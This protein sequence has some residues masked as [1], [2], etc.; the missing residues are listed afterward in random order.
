MY[1][2]QRKIDPFQTNLEH[3]I[4]FFTSLFENGLGYSSI[5]SARSA[6][7]A[8]GLKFDTILVGQHPLVIRYLKGV[9][10]LR[11]TRP[12]YSCVWDVQIVLN[13]LCKLSPVKLI[14]R[15]ELTLKLTM[16]LALTN[17]T[18]VQSLHLIS[19]NSVI[20]LKSE[21]VF[22]VDG[23]LKQSRPGYKEPVISCKCYPPDRRL[24]IFTVLKEYL[25]RT[26]D[27]RSQGDNKLLI[28][29]V[30]PFKPVSKDTISR[31][32]KVVMTRSGINTDIFGS[33]SVRAASV[34]KAK[35]NKVPL[36]EILSKA[37]W[38]N[39]RTFAKYYDKDIVK[40]T[41]AEAVIRQK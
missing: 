5:N 25:F 14:S 30:K 29:Y 20:K 34:S 3:V 27:L 13:Y 35:L 1:C 6:L 23:L 26:K 39:A 36:N 24:C 22:V 28:S 11:P 19:V 10:N 40:D 41:F 2:N 32:I 8:L 9:F 17:A 16:L 12:K 18:R 7:S 15:K 37:G 31:W 33:H 21:F 4:E 38:S